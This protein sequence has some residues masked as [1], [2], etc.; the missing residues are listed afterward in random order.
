MNGLFDIL[1][2]ILLDLIIDGSVAASQSKKIPK[3]VRYILL[4]FIFLIYIFI[5]GTVTWF[6]I[7]MLK[8]NVTVGIVVLLFDLT[9]FALSVW[10]FIR[11][12]IKKQTSNIFSKIKN[13]Y[14]KICKKD[15]RYIY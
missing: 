13:N 9:F 3:P 15:K 8:E 5:F 7:D 12:Y 4:L 6:G 14:K 10:K 2:D 11:T 1:F